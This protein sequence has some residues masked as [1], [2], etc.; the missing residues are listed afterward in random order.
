MSDFD[1][2]KISATTIAGYYSL[3]DRSDFSWFE[4]VLGFLDWV[5]KN[6]QY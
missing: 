5:F 3:S 6:R 2:L 4:P 1:A